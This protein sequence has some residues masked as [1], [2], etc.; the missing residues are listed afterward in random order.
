MLARRDL[1]YWLMSNEF[2]MSLDTPISLGD[3]RLRTYEADLRQ[4]IAH[5]RQ[6]LPGVGFLGLH[7][8]VRCAARVDASAYFFGD[9]G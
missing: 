1:A 8:T 6:T 3:N 9:Q 5:I 7:T 4:H 2:P